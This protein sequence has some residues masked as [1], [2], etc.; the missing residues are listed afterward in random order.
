MKRNTEALR[1]LDEGTSGRA[2]ANV[3]GVSEKTIRRI[4]KE[5][6]AN[7]RSA[8]KT[9]EDT[10][11]IDDST[12]PW[13]DNDHGFFD[14]EECDTTPAV[15]PALSMAEATNRAMRLGWFLLRHPEPI[16]GV[17]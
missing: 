2:V 8:Q 10:T 17:L 16:T 3:L 14:E 7:E 15:N 1:L 6:A 13:D 9:Q 12:S 5:R 11:P 4:K